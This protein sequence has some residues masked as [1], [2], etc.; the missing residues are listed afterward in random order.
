MGVQLLAHQMGG[1]KPVWLR[2]KTVPPVTQLGCH[3]LEFVGY[4]GNVG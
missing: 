1:S 2:G 4:L 3:C